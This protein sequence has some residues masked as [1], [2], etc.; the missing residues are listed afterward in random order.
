MPIQPRVR[1]DL[2]GPSDGSWRPCRSG[3]R[4]LGEFGDGGI[5]PSRAGNYDLGQRIHI[6]FIGA[7]LG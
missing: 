2:Y 3:A 5:E 4:F 1:P 6:F 7:V